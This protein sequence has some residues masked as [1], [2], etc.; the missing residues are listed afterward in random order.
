MTRLI[1]A[2]WYM[3]RLLKNSTIAMELYWFYSKQLDDFMQQIARSLYRK[4]HGDEVC[5]AV[6]A[7]LLEYGRPKLPKNLAFFSL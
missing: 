2:S 6:R 5:V 1:M 3:T 4:D 7:L